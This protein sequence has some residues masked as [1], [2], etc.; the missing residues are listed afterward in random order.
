MQLVIGVPTYWTAAG[1]E[2]TGL[3]F[4]HPTP[5]G[6][7]GTLPRLLTSL[8]DLPAPSFQVVVVAAP[9]A[10]ELGPAME[11]QLQEQLAALALPYPLLLV[12][13]T[14]LAR[15]RDFCHRRGP[16]AAATL[17][18]LDSY[19]AIR[20]V[21]L[22][23]A[24]LLAADLLVCLDDDERV[25]DPAFFR[26]LQEDCQE[27]AAREKVFGL[28]G[29]YLNPNGT[30]FAAEPQEPWALAWPKLRWLNEA[31]AA[32]AASGRLSQTTVA[33]GGNMIFP[34]ALYRLLPFDPL[35]TR[36]E[37]IDYVLNA[38]MFGIPFYLDPALLV[39]HEPPPK[40]HPLW[41]RLRQDLARFVYTRQKLR[42]QQPEP[43]MVRV[44]V[45][46]L[47]PYPG[48]FLDE[49]LDL[50]AYQAH[51]LVAAAYLDQ[52]EVEA[53]R[54]TLANLTCLQDLPEAGVTFATYRRLVDCWRQTQDWLSRPEV[55]A[56][57]RALLAA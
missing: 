33:L 3:I 57:A 41:L 37:D 53:A 5:L 12:G 27:L 45:A 51:T 30:V 31:I 22:L 6:T 26:R 49:E 34:K 50:R 40:P 36:G 13:P 8:A 10:P 25:T 46:E 28:A 24:N 4:D 21:I 32:A 29:L 1:Q 17:L 9:T 38:R 18:H 47:R 42:G 39:V 55:Q 52:G 20:N 23:V 35:I 56:E 43:G 2:A 7:V 16:T 48:N 54:Q 15:L 44:T 14:Q 11:Q 19:G